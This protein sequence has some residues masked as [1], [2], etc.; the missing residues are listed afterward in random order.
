[1]QAGVRRV[2]RNI[3]LR[4][5]LISLGVLALLAAV[6]TGCGGG[7]G[8]RS[9]DDP[10][11]LFEENFSGVPDGS[12]PVGWTIITQQAATEEGPADWKVRSG[13][14][15]QAS[16]VQAPNT[17]GLS[18]AINYEGTMAVVGDTAWTNIRFQAELIPRDDDGIG[19]V[20][21]WRPSVV[22]PDGNFY[23]L[24]MIQDSASDGPKL[25]L[26]KRIDGEWEI[27]D[28]KTST[29]PGYEENGRYLVEVD[30]V[31]YDFTIKLNQ[32]IMFEFE[33]VDPNLPKGI[34][35]FFCYG[36]EGADFDNVRVYRRGP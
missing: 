28:E 13:R 12:I 8:T 15:H 32:T 11:L 7:G 36:E 27:L 10:D 5:Y 9:G 1:M 34:V 4:H 25:R 35:G 22:D 19:V 16:N 30:M 31:V 2:T 23:R 17:P 6:G 33:D 3:H 21:R 14:L 29:Y 20:F 24:L 18:H 26:D